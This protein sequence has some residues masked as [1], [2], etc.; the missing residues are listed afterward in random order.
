MDIE[1]PIY[2]NAGMTAPSLIEK[3]SWHWQACWLHP[4]PDD[5]QDSRLLGNASEL[6]TETGLAY[7]WRSFACCHS[8]GMMLSGLGSTCHQAWR[9]KHPIVDPMGD[10]NWREEEQQQEL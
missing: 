1:T 3:L 8:K 5:R 9:K 2:R 6:P 7:E 4:K 10:G